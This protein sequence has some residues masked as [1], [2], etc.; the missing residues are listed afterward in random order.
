[1]KDIIKEL[2]K[3]TNKILDQNNKIL[4]INAR[5]LCSLADARYVINDKHI[6]NFKKTLT[7]WRI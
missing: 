1:M 4:E 3:T 2:Y 6:K 7:I 5:L